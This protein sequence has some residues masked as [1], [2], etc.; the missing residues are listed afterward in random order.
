MQAAPERPSQRLFLVLAWALGLI[1]LAPCLLSLALGVWGPWR[2]RE[3]HA[4]EA[5]FR[6]LPGV[7]LVRTWG[8]E[9]VTLED[10]S[11]V[12]DVAGKGPVTFF[13]LEEEDFEDAERLDIA[14]LGPLTVVHCTWGHQGTYVMDTGEPVKSLG[15]GS[16]FSVGRA[17]AFSALF[18]FPLRTVQDV[19]ARHDEIQ[20]VLRGWPRAPAWRELRYELPP[21]SRLFGRSYPD[22]T[23]VMRYAVTDD[24]KVSFQDVCR[25]LETR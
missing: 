22:P 11:A 19:L 24:P 9:D 2:Y 13:N 1:S 21:G 8:N 17:G 25:D 10:I 16:G 18:P 23:M 6:A 14:E 5:R 4:V 3:F 12:I 15:H 7:T 20:E